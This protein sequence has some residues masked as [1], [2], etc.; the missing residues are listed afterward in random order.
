M[1]KTQADLL[2]I[3]SSLAT[4]ILW[5]MLKQQTER[6]LVVVEDIPAPEKKKDSEGATQTVKS[7]SRLSLQIEPKPAIPA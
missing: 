6:K 3:I 1:N 5:Q 4:W 7:A 2:I